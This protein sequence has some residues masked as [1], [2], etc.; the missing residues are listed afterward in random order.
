MTFAE[1]EKYGNFI[2]CEPFFATQRTLFDDENFSFCKRVKFSL[3][4]ISVSSNDVVFPGSYLHPTTN[5]LLDAC[6]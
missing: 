3:T 5:S 1:K 2:F 6:S 4:F